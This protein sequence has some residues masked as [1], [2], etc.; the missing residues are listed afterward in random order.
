MS[1]IVEDGTGRSDAES[2]CSVATADTYHTAFGNAAWAA[3]LEAD[4][5]AALRQATRYLDSKY[6]NRWLGTRVYEDQALAFPRSG[7]EDYDGFT[8]DA[9]SVPIKIQNATAEMALHSLTDDLLPNEDTPGVIKR[10]AVRVGSIEEDIEYM[11]G[12]TSVK[13]YT[14]A[15][16]FVA[17]YIRNSFSVERG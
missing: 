7:I 5:E 6:A 2:Y 14:V 15:Q 3:L 16:A 12:K 10:E 1:L 13:K 17:P 11:G 4:K 8:V 9:D